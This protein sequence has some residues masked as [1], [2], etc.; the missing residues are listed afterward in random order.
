[1]SNWQFD[2]TPAKLA[3]CVKDYRD[4]QGLFRALESVLPRYGINTV[5]RVAAFLAQCGHESADFT[6]LQE[7]LNYSA[8]G[9]ANTWPSRYAVKGD[10]GKII[11]PVRPNNKA[12]QLHRKPE[13]IANDAY[14]NRMGNGAPETGDG[15]RYRGRGALQTT[16]KE[17]YI[18]FSKKINR[19]LDDTVKYLE[20]LEGAIESACW[21]WE[22]V[23]IS[24]WADKRDCVMVTKLING[25]D[26]GLADRLERTNRNLEVLK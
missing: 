14:A 17:N 6:V 2:F 8:Q 22:R 5:D 12:W 24:P 1:M 21:Y 13:A 15:W 25:G 16:G 10:D 19:S 4:S 9:M 23:K 11:K 3:K 20:T 26:I 18:N 7:N